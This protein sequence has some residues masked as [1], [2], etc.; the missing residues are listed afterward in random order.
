MKTQLLTCTSEDILRAGQILRTGGLCVIPT[1]TVYGLAA[2]ALDRDAVL[3]I[4]RAKNRPAD[5]PLI[6]HIS[7]LD[8][9]S[10]VVRKVPRHALELAEKF[11]PGPLTLVMPRASCIGDEV[12]GGLDT[13]GVRMPSNEHARAIIDAAGVPLAAPSCNLSGKPSPTCLR[14][15][16]EDMDGR[17]DAI[18]DGG[19]CSVGVESTVLSLCGERPRLLRPGAVTPGMIGSVTGEVDIDPGIDGEVAE[20]VTPSSPGMKYRH[21]APKAAVTICVGELDKFRTLVRERGCAALCFD[22]EGESLGVPYVEYGAEH[23]HAA[24]CRRIFTA[25]REL[26]EMGAETV[27]A[28]CPSRDG[29]GLAVYNRLTRAAGGRFLFM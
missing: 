6:V 22:G 24:Q 1:E 11:W 20:D 12:T 28:R 10:Q 16:L 26:D 19:E 23:D 5:N 21:Y 29:E 27:L 7:S 18:V 3:G 17:V 8:Q 25:L 14:H 15:V 13:V 2:N 4:F 9:L